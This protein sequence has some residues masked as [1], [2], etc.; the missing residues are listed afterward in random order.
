VDTD[1]TSLPRVRAR[2]VARESLRKLT[3]SLT[4][5]IM[6]A[7]MHEPPLMSEYWSVKVCICVSCLRVCLWM[8]VMLCV[9]VWGGGE[10]GRAGSRCR[11]ADL[12]GRQEADEAGKRRTK[13]VCMYVMLCVCVCVPCACMCMYVCVCVC[14][15]A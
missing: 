2:Y 10:G 8:Y 12:E 6:L 14:V 15:R 13:F 7:H 4:S 9:C 3:H 11:P 1:A 5:N